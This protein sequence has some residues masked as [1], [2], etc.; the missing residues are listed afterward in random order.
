MRHTAGHFNEFGGTILTETGA[1][2]R[3]LALFDGL[4]TDGLGAWSPGRNPVT[5]AVAVGATIF[6]VLSILR[7]LANIRG[8]IQ[9]SRLGHDEDAIEAHRTMVLLTLSAAT[10]AL[11][12][13]L[14]Q[15]VVHQSR[16]VLTLV[17][18]L[19]LLI[20]AGLSRRGRFLSAR[21]LLAVLFFIAY[22]WTGTMLALQH[23]N[24][25]AI[26][27]AKAWVQ[28][29]AVRIKLDAHGTAD[30]LVVCPPVVRDHLLLQG[31][32]VRILEAERARDLPMIDSAYADAHGFTQLLTVGDYSARIKL[33]LVERRAFHHNP[34]VNR[35]WPTIEG[36]RY[37]RA[38]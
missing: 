7:A 4:W 9:S 12:I 18:P 6:G 28:A 26:A 38:P 35:L 20:A 15:N 25:T 21:R 2:R 22:A 1:A 3:I 8:A 34:H 27:Q 11:W 14:F 30:M 17:V 29:Q 32:R 33:P 36:Y 16:H 10:Y 5:I 13:L 24:P 19:L 31:V 37:G 23:R